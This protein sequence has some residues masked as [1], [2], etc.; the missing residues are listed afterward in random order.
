MIFFIPRYS[1]TSAVRLIARGPNEEET[2]QFAALLADTL[3]NAIRDVNAEHGFDPEA[4]S[5]KKDSE[6]DEEQNVGASRDA[7]GRN[8]VN[9]RAVERPRPPLC[10]RVLGPAPAPFAKLRGNFRFHLQ[11][12]GAPS[13]LLREAVKRVVEAKLKT[14]KDVQWIVDVDPLDS[15]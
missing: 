8:Y 10:A 2:A 13:N 12:L 5:K 1:F 9:L 14:P 11:V 4:I 7:A 15:L 3:R 6:K